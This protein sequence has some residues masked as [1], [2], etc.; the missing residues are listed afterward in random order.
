MTEVKI[1]TA[2]EWMTRDTMTLR[3]DAELLQAIRQMASKEISAALSIPLGTVM[4]RLYRGRKLMEAAMLEYAREHGYLRSGEP[5]KM[6]S[7]D[8][9]KR[10]AS[11]PKS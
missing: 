6:R 3:P 11:E 8:E 4:S 1:P 7:R 2:R 10:A 5:A 9:A